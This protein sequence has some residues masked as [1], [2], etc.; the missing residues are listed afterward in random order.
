MSTMT[1]EPPATPRDRSLAL[2]G[3]AILG[4]LIL[5]ALIMGAALARPAQAQTAPGP[6]DGSETLTMMGELQRYTTTADDTLLDIARRFNLGFV[7]LRAANPG[8][9]P[10]LPGAGVDLLLPTAHLLPD[11]P[12]E[13][14]VVNLAEM[15][16]YHFVVPGAEP[17][18]HPIGVGREGRS[19]P[20]GTTTIGR[21]AADPAW[22]PPASI[23][24]EKPELPA[25]VPPGPEN[26]LGRHALYLGWPA[27][28][29]HG[30][31]K[32][33]GIG[34]RVSSGCLRMYPED[35]EQLFNTV[36]VGTQV[37]VVDQP[38]KVAWV[39][40]TLYVE[41]HPS[42][43][44]AD[45]LEDDGAFRYETPEGLLDMVR[46]AAGDAFDRV[47]LTAVLRAGTERRGY[48]VAVLGASPAAPSPTADATPGPLPLRL[49]GSDDV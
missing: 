43:S 29:I 17:A 46:A 27:Y 40:E 35:I 12:Q 15:R 3:A 31:N 24:A 47:D 8:V 10:W 7:A 42:M 11:A 44:Q 39:G 26:P 20:L 6:S 21:K 45:Q 4:A 33:L 25:M 41:V 13:G 37:T 16:L 18:S 32:P 30:T 2:K 36:P 28:L 34:R 48:P 38:I 14:L 23:R 22:Y 9:D 5:A 49:D 1:T 19:T